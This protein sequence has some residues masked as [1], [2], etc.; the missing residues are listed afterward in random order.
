MYKMLVGEV[1]DGIPG[2]KGIGLKSIIKRFPILLESEEV[3]IDKLLK[4]SDKQLSLLDEKGKQVNNYKIYKDVLAS[5]VQLTLNNDLIQLHDVD[6][7]RNTKI[8]ISNQ[9]K[10][11]INRL[12]KHEFL[13]LVLEDKMNAGLKNPDLWLREIFTQLDAYASETHE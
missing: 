4:Y 13:R 5:K 7:T 3:T 9:I 1:S 8:L 11:P 2:I 12:L 6:I 10:R